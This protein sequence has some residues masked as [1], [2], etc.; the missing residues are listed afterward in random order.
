MGQGEI[1]ALP[2]REYGDKSAKNAEVNSKRERDGA[3]GRKRAEG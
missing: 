2:D 1:A 3:Q